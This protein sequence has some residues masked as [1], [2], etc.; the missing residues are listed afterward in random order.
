[1]KNIKYK[2]KECPKCTCIQPTKYILNT[3]GVDTIDAEYEKRTKH[4]YPEYVYRLFKK[5]NNNTC[6]L[7]GFDPIYAHPSSLVLHTIPVCPPLCRP[8]VKQGNGKMSQDHI[9]IRY[10]EVLKSNSIIANYLGK[11]QDREREK[12]RE[13]LAHDIATLFDNEPGGGFPQMPRN[14][15]QPHRTFGQRLRGTIPKNGRIRGN[16]L[17]CRVEMSA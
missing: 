10:E 15:P 5:I 1:M 12:F 13:Y 8:A 9:T 16:L 14:S 11:N 6:V 7:L 2:H 4:I 17:S 3:R